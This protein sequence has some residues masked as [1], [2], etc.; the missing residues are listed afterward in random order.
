MTT[1]DPRGEAFVTDLDDTGNCP[2]GARCERCG[3]SEGLSVRTAEI[4]LGVLCLTL[5]P[6]CVRARDLPHMKLP[7]IA[8]LVADHA[9]H[10][11]VD[12]DE[13]P[14]GTEGL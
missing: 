9:A 1:T 5:C 4:P 6:I 8:R 14:A 11:G 10:L 12:V 7:T 3:A 13:M 2:T